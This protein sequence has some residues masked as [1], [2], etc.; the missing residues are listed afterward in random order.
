MIVPLP[1]AWVHCPCNL[2]EVRSSFTDNAVGLDYLD[3]LLAPGGRRARGAIVV[4]VLY[5]ST[6]L[7]ML[8]SSPYLGTPEK[9]NRELARLQPRTVA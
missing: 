6:S 1:V 7:V 3:W 5:A 4:T 9:T 8:L 2:A